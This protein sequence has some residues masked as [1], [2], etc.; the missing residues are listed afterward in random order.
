MA[1]LLP[2]RTGLG[3]LDI[4]AALVDLTLPAGLPPLE[5]CALGT[6]YWARLRLRILDPNAL[7]AP[8]HPWA[9]GVCGL[10]RNKDPSEISKP[11]T[12]I[13]IIA[14]GTVGDPG[15]FRAWRRNA[16]AAADPVPRQ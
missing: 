13:S 2:P 12:V 1:S 14:E 4:A 16:G 5:G 9:W 11:L 7:S 15:L 8:S 3:D 6:V 10:P